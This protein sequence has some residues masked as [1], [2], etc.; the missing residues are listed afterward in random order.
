MKRLGLEPNDIQVLELAYR[1]CLTL[2]AVERAHAVG[3]LGDVESILAGIDP[4]DVRIVANDLEQLWRRARLAPVLVGTEPRVEA[5]GTSPTGD[6]RSEPTRLGSSVPP[7][8][9]P[10]SRR[11]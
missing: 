7:S 3:D 2:K 11:A 4:V 6:D 1:Y 8:F 10:E 9:F 5:D